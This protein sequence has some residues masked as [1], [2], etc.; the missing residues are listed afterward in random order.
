MSCMM[1]KFMRERDRGQQAPGCASADGKALLMQY[2]A[3]RAQDFHS[4]IRSAVH[5]MTTVGPVTLAEVGAGRQ[6]Y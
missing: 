5:G 4:P 6:P 1:M 3:V 2:V